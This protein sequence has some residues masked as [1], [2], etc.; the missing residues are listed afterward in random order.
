MLIPTFRQNM[1]IEKFALFKKKGKVNGVLRV[2]IYNFFL[3]LLQ[4]NEKVIDFFTTFYI[5]HKN[6]IKILLK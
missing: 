1:N 3:N 4:E 5:S 6:C 2:L